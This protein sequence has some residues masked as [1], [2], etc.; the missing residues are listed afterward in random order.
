MG[1]ASLIPSN[2]PQS[3]F[4]KSQ[5]TIFSS[6]YSRCITETLLFQ[7]ERTWFRTY[8]PIFMKCTTGEY[9]SADKAGQRLFQV[10]Y[11]SWCKK[12]GDVLEMEG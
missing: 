1:T 4:H 3:K 11:D 6:I 2:F 7:E 5:D 8:F 9:V 12:S 10:A